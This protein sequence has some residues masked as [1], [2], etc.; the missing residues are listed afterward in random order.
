MAITADAQTREHYLRPEVKEIITKFAL[1][2]EGAWR[3]LN[4]DFWRWYSHF[5]EGRLLN[6]TR[7]Y[8]GLTSTYRTLYQTLNVF[9]PS[10]W[11][12][13]HPAEEI[14]NDCPLGT[15]AETE[16]Y[17]LGTDIDAGH[18]C[19]IEDP[20]VTHAVEAAA[21]FLVD[22]L[23]DQGVHASV[24][25]LFSGGGIY[26]EIHHAICKPN[27]VEGREE[28]FEMATDAYN[29]LIGHIS[30]KFFEVHPEYI[31]KVKYDALNNAKRVFKCV[32]SI[33]KKKPYAVTPLNRDAI[34][35][36][37]ERARV[38]LSLEMIEEAGVWYSTYDPAEREPLLR[39]LDKF[40][41]TEEEKKRSEHH[42]KEIW[43]SGTKTDQ[44][45]FPPCI[46]HILDT[47]NHGEGKTRFTAVLS[48]YLHQA[49]WSQ[50]EAWRLVQLVSDRNGLDNAD[51]IFESIFGRISCPSCQTIQNDGAG[52][53]HLGLRGLGVCVPDEKCDTSPR[54]YGIAFFMDAWC[55][56]AQSAREAAMR[57]EEEK[58]RNS[59]PEAAAGVQVKT[60][61]ISQEEFD[62]FKLPEGPKF[63][64]NLPAD[65]FITRFMGYGTA[66]S[67]A[68]RVYWF[69]SALFILSVIADKKI[70]FVTKM[71]TFYANLW[72]YILGD[73]S[74]A[75]KSTA[76]KKA[77]AMLLA[78]LGAKFA[79]ACVPNTFS[80]EAFIEHMSN[81]QHAP[82]IRDEAAGVLSIMQKDY[83]R[84][85]KDDLMQLFDCSPITRMLRTSREKGKQTR[86][87]V[88]DPYLNLYFASTGAALGFNLNLIDK[89]TGFLVRFVFAYPQGEKEG[90][91][92]PLDQGEAYHSE[93]E[94][95]CISQLSTL[96]AQI[97]VIPSCI[98]MTHSPVA[99]LYYN[100]WQELRD[101]EAARLKDGYSS[102]IFSRLNPTVIKF[103]MLFEMGSTDFDP[104]RPIREE[105]F[106]EACRL[107]D[108]YF[109]PT[110]RAVYDIIGTANKD[111]QIEKIVLYLSRHGGKATRK[112]IMRD[113]KIKSKEVTEYL[114]TME[115]CEMIETKS[116][117]NEVTK[118]NTSYVF[119]NAQ[120]VENVGK[121]VKVDRVEKVDN[122]IITVKEPITVPTIST[123]STLATLPTFHVNGL[124][125]KG[126]G[127][128]EAAPSPAHKEA[129]PEKERFKA[130]VQ[131]R[132]RN[133]CMLCGEHFDIPLQMGC[134]GGYMCAKCHRE[135]P[136]SEPAK[137]DSQTKIE[138]QS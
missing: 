1:P 94:E 137:A 64:I 33:H 96:A 114:L 6:A 36:D 12:V 52:Y 13:G 32:L 65:H 101:K 49:G 7:D 132:N 38:P 41:P 29:S 60:N 92:M 57:L 16:A 20:E 34:K 35:I 97:D 11:M 108:E 46:R 82:W 95:I 28:F 15:L 109:M 2:G 128:K 125:F 23:R 50:D 89:E 102:Q 124:D 10:L 134:S 131:S 120:R 116:V 9:D 129:K 93:L 110:A 8:E 135:G 80:P 100:T 30:E 39:L 56:T 90:E 88:D 71:D 14:S 74:L 58:R 26:V 68:Y 119:L 98:G 70:K 37:F 75:R 66:I 4:G 44:K 127:K 111:N 63:S 17:T 136:P 85:F 121:V 99:R 61:E 118:R 79:N 126:V 19:N 62:N 103:A 5:N 24:W 25:I 48:A 21:Q 59:P 22:Y 107:V 104:T 51:H 113:V 87:N 84:G 69:M 27:T 40:K 122:E 73:S 54:D 31:G 130:N 72:V 117:Y 55:R 133:T 123:F 86:F 42:S 3:A 81:Y 106:V 76:V 53:P 83:M 105:Y 67:D 77:N 112:E 47:A 115:E 91:Y 78:V 138:A 43:V 45:D 18:G